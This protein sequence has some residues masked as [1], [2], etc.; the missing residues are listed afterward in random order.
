[1]FQVSINSI[2]K[3]LSYCQ[4]TKFNQN[5]N[6]IVDAARPPNRPPSCH[7]DQRQSI[8]RNLLLKNPPKKNIQVICPQFDRFLWFIG[9]N[10][11]I[12]LISLNRAEIGPKREC[13]NQLF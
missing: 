2:Q 13:L 1:M 8:S 6:L 10:Q 5:F 4:K 7:T 3:H 11:F 9:K 12:Y